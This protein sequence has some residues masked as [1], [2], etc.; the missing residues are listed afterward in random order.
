MK[1]DARVD[2]GSKEVRGLNLK[3][4][5][6]GACWDLGPVMRHLFV[7]NTEAKLSIFFPSGHVE[8]TR[9]HSTKTLA[10][11]GRNSRSAT[12]LIYLDCT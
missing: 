2:G 5:D 7:S 9:T 8:R 10:C 12:F 11:N 6:R 3:V 1:T 4:E